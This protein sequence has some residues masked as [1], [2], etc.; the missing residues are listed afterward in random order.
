MDTLHSS[1]GGV[2]EV[3]QKKYR[4]VTMVLQG[5]ASIDFFVFFPGRLLD[6]CLI[7][8]PKI[9]QPNV[10]PVYNPFSQLVPQLELYSQF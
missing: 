8:F 4:S 2:K 10:Q 7:K 3:L 6:M 5:T 1:Y 9:Y